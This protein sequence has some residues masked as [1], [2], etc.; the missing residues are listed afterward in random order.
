MSGPSGTGQ[1]SPPGD[2][3]PGGPGCPYCGRPVEPGA[4]WCSG[5]GAN[6]AGYRP[7]PYYP[8]GA[9]RTPA[10]ATAALVLS[11]LSFLVCPIVLAVVALILAASARRDI[12][13]G[14]GAVGGEGIVTASRIVAV[15]NIVL[16]VISGIVIAVVL[17]SA[18]HVSHLSVSANTPTIPAYVPSTLGT[19]PAAPTNTTN[20]TAPA[21]V[22][23]V[24][25]PKPDGSSPRY[26]HF[27]AAPPRCIDPAH[28]YTVTF[29]T[30]VGTFTAVL[31]PKLAPVTVNSFVF[32]AGYHYFDGIVF[33]RVVPGFVVQGGDPTGTG[34]GGPGYQ[35]A[36]ELPPAGAYKIGSIAMANSGPNTNGSQFFIITGS[37]GVALPPNYSLFGMV[38]SGMDVVN[39]IDADGAADPNPPTVI[40]RM[41]KVTVTTT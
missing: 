29:Q 19:E 39:R 37:Q 4:G 30:D 5:C 6:L 7:P 40:H 27:D 12:D 41:I 33:H 25:C 24:G 18:N 16:S 8:P 34:S 1:G 13:A 21:A 31:D 2:R 38:T 28:T 10:S 3:P 20:T 35:F 23:Q 22:G 17:V 36:D 14:R 11:V 9:K 15:L 26:Q 32:L